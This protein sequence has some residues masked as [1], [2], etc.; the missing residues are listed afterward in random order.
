MSIAHVAA[1]AGVSP[2]TV[3]NVLNRPGRVAE[4]TRRVVQQAIDDTGY[5][6]HGLASR[7]RALENRSLGLVVIDVGNPFFTGVVRGA[8]DVTSAAGYTLLLCDSDS[9][10]ERERAHLRFLAEH[11]VA[12]LLLVPSD[13]RRLGPFVDDLVARGIAVV[14]VDAPFTDRTRCSIGIDDVRGGALAGTHLIEL[15]RRRIVFVSVRG[16][17]GPFLDRGRGLRRVASAA[18]GVTVSGVKLATLDPHDAFGAVDEILTHRPDAVFCANDLAALGVMRGL[19]DRGIDVPG[20][21]AVVGYDDIPYAALGPVPLT[22]IR[23]PGLEMGR[24]AAQLLIDECSGAVHEHRRVD[25][26]PELV[27]RAS[28]VAPPGRH[29]TRR[30]ARPPGTAR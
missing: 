13:A 7:L 10:P 21:V 6:R 16:R 12:G 11:R 9:Q 4:V 30:P 1:R 23:Q 14:W 26:Q 27:V 24:V 8:Q 28:T 3:S 2:A 15:G 18:A 25:F 29:P 20:D 17:F 5:V 19:F 22:T